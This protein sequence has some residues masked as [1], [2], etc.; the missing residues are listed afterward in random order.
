MSLTRRG[1][2]CLCGLLVLVLA[3]NVTAAARQYGGRYTQE[4]LA[5]ARANCDKHEWAADLRNAAVERAAEWVSRSDGELWAMVPG[6]D[7]PRCIDVTMD[8]K[9]KSGPKRLG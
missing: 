1:A 4:R 6:Q 2:V 9:V 7:L 8:R 5:N 3:L